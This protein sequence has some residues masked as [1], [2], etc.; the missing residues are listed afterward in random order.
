MSPLAVAGVLVARI[1]GASLNGRGMY[2][3]LEASQIGLFLRRLLQGV[4][5]I[6]SRLAGGQV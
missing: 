5:T 3:R 4:R 1:S 2:V 6:S